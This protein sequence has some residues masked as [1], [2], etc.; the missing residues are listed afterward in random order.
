MLARLLTP[1]DFGLVTMVTTFSLLFCSIGLNGFTE[2]IVQAEEVTH[3]QASNLFWINIGAGVVLTAVFAAIGQLLGYFYHNALVPQVAEGLSLTILVGSLSVIHLA[4]LNRATCFRAISINTVVA[5]FVCVI[6]S[7]V[8]GLAGWRYWAL[9]WGSVAQQLSTSV[10]AW[11]LCRWTPGLPRRTAG[12]A[13]FV[14]FAINVYSHF[15]LN[16]FSGNTDNLLV[17]WRFG[18]P[19][20]GFYKKA[21]DLFCLPACQIL[22]PMGLVIVTALSRL[23]HDRKQY[24]RHFLLGISV[25]ALVSMGIGG[26][27]TLVGPDLIRLLLGSGW[28]QTARIFTFFGPGIG[29]ML[30]CN[31]HGWIHLS[32]GRPDRWFRWAIVEF[33]CTVGLFLLALPWGPVGIASAWTVSYF[34]LMFPALWY[35]GRPIGFELTP[36]VSVIWKY[37]AAAVAAGCATGLIVHIVPMLAAMPGAFPAFARLVLVSAVFVALYLGAVLA[38]HRGFEPLREAVRLLRHLKPGAAAAGDEMGDG[39]DDYKQA[40]SMAGAQ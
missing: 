33:A 2:G 17:G 19:A 1:A 20:L 16:Y 23:K 12:T 14:K 26:N 32:I 38:L 31:T 4:L 37:F 21:F 5:R 35:A 15:T 28:E 18:A 13:E 3:Q 7:I 27:F 25:L 36:V 34:V 29:V 40:V 8:F 6:V 30:L 22:S 39:E 24:E 10:G 9:V 11:F